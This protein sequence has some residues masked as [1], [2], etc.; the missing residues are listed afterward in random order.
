ISL[1]FFES[2]LALLASASAF[3]AAILSS[4]AF[5]AA[6]SAACP[7]PLGGRMK[8]WV[9]MHDKKGNDDLTVFSQDKLPVQWVSWLR[10][11]RTVAPTINDLIQEERRREMVQ[12]RAKA[13]DQQWAKRKLE[14]EK[15]QED[16]Q[17]EVNRLSAI[18]KAGEQKVQTTQPT[19]QGD[20]FSPGEW[21]PTRSKR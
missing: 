13:L 19:G 15:I 2:S 21:T 8:R 1:A 3:S 4:S 6:A 17:L 18:D 9:Q 11:T 7:N 16:E 5:L 14:L 20:T 12:S 10:H